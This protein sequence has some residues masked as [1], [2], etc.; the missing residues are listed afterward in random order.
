[1]GDLSVMT[2]RYLR[3]IVSDWRSVLLL[4]AQAP[5]LGLLFAAVLSRQVF[6]TPLVPRTNAR[7]FVLAALL[8]MV[9]IGASNSVREIVKERRTFLRE[10]AVGVSAVSLVASR[11]LVL[12]V[13]TIVQAVVLYYTA[14]SRQQQPLTDGVLLGDS[15]GGGP[16][17]LMI[18]LSLVGLGSVGIGL[19][20]S[21]LV[22]DVNKAMAILPIVLIPVVLFSGLLIPTTGRIGVEQLSWINPVM[23]G[24]SAAAVVADV[25]TNEGCD[26]ND[27][28][29]VIQQALLGRTV[30][31]SNPRWQQTT[32]SQVVNLGMAVVQLV[33][34]AGL[35]FVAADRSTR[36]LRS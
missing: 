24:S 30:S 1:M 16:V 32:G 5:V 4:S 6:I 9:W 19:L 36:N 8:A 12:S 35:S 14:T 34:L 3:S 10:R 33:V 22:S 23:W 28:Q 27:L 2:S 13:I 26:P 29:T 17:E 18:A 15:F 31:C 25:L 20:I 11:W 21:A 7:E